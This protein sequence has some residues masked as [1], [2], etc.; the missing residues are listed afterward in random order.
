MG[1]FKKEQK[2]ADL[3]NVAEL[4]PNSA[5]VIKIKKQLTAIENAKSEYDSKIQNLKAD[6][7]SLSNAEEQVKQVEGL[8]FEAVTTMLNNLF[9]KRATVNPE[10]VMTEITIYSDWW[11]NYSSSKLRE[12]AD[13][14]SVL[15]EEQAEKLEQLES[16]ENIQNSNQIDELY[17]NVIEDI[18]EVFDRYC[19]L[20]DETDAYKRPLSIRLPVRTSLTEKEEQIREDAIQAE[21]NRAEQQRIVNEQMLARGQEPYRF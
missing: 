1:L 15:F 12:I 21:S 5:T 7:D 10:N 9:K 4:S 11:N 19:R 16:L 17:Q 14:L 3:I 13:E 2:I 18:S 6:A 8:G 20:S